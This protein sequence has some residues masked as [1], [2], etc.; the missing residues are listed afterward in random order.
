MATPRDILDQY[1]LSCASG[2]LPHVPPLRRLPD[3]YYAPW[4]GAI[5]ELPKLVTAGNV[6]SVV[7]D[8]P[9]LSTQYLYTEPEWRRAYVV[10]GFLTQAY[11]WSEDVP[12][13]VWSERRIE[14]SQR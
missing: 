12:S 10:L 11:I 9:I 8:L 14:E 5:S 7:D 6:R 4:E 3:P 1:G 13:E 2:F